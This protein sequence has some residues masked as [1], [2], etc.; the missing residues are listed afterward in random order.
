MKHHAE[1]LVAGGDLVGV[2]RVEFR[3]Q[4]VGGRKA[5]GHGIGVGEFGDV[6]LLDAIDGDVTR[7]GDVA[8]LAVAHHAVLPEADRLGLFAGADRG[9]EFFLEEQHGETASF[10]VAI[11]TTWSPHLN[12]A[13][14]VGPQL[15]A[16]LGASVER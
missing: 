12:L 13:D 14:W 2:E 11:R 3:A 10:L 1:G 9:Q 5:V 15:R 16:L 7:T 4:G 8:P 6:D